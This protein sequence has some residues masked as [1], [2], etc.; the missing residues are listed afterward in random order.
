MP[1]GGTARVGDGSARLRP[2]H[3]HERRGPRGAVL[4]RGGRRLAL[5]SARGD[6]EVDAVAPDGHRLHCDSGDQP[7]GA[8]AVGEG[9]DGAGAA[10]DLAVEALEAVAGA[11]ANPVCLGER[12]VRGAVDEAA[13]EAG[14]RLRELRSEAVAEAAELLLSCVESLGVQHG[15]QLA[16]EAV[17]VARRHLAEHVAH[18]V[19]GAAL[20]P[21]LGQRLADGGDQPGMLVGDHQPNAGQATL[22]QL[23][24]QAGPARLGLLGA[25]VHR[26]QA[27]MAIGTDAIR[28]QRR[29]VL[30]AAGP[31]R[32]DERGVEVEIRDGVGDGLRAERLDLV[33]KPAG[34]PARRRPTD[35]LA[36]QRLGDRRDVPRGRT[37]HVRLGDGV[38]DLALAPTVPSQRLGRGAAGARA[39]DA[40]ADLAGGGDDAAVVAA[41]ANVDALIGPLVWPRADQALEFLVEDDLQR[42]LDRQPEARAEVNLEVF[43][44]RDHEL[45]RVGSKGS[46]WSLHGGSSW[47]S[48]LGGSPFL[49]WGAKKVASTQL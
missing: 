11:D 29:Y 37:A 47:V 34:H 49:S 31:S 17:L 44:R 48:Q 18:L 3:P 12:V 38:V 9:A 41:V 13:V 33:L 2:W 24:Q 15:D 28:D 16:A 10:L 4:A 30:D 32:V 14:D 35:A 42:P 22:D 43:L 19:D 6:V 46:F 23:A 21:R 39:T 26:E 5:R 36:E 25:H 8:G 45:S 20:S 7:Q 40:N 27:A 1:E